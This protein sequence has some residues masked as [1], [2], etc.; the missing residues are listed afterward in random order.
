[1][2]INFIGIYTRDS[3][4]GM[5]TEVGV[6]ADKQSVGLAFPRDGETQTLLNSSMEPPGR[7]ASM[8]LRLLDASLS[9]Q[10]DLR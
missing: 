4:T 8:W 6:K 10:Q 1:M 9:S 2:K 7:E 5:D 3:R